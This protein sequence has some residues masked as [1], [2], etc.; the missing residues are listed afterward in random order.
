MYSAD[1]Y[2]GLLDERLDGSLY[3]LFRTRGDEAPSRAVERLEPA[4]ADAG[5]AAALG[6]E[7]GSP[8]L[9]VE[10]EGYGESGRLLERS[11]DLFR[12]DRTRVVWESAILGP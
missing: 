3:E 2:P 12:G 8:V 11:R 5:D 9:L 6:I 1:A 10:R 7:P 4:L